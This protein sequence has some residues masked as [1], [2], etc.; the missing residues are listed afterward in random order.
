MALSFFAYISSLSLFMQDGS[1]SMNGD[2]WDLVAVQTAISDGVDVQ[3]L[4]QRVADLLDTQPGAVILA[5][6]RLWITLESGPS[7]LLAHSISYSNFAFPMARAE[8]PS[9]AGSSL[10][11]HVEM[12]PLKMRMTYQAYELVRRSL[13]VVSP[14][15]PN[16]EP[17]ASAVFGEGKTRAWENQSSLLSGVEAKHEDST[18]L[19]LPTVMEE[20]AEELPPR[21]ALSTFGEQHIT[22][23]LRG[24]RVF[25]VNDVAGLDLPIASAKLDQVNM[26]VSALGQKRSIVASLALRADFYNS[27]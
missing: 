7:F 5:P 24:L 6:C 25:L 20:N 10:R 8:I 27:E 26:L 13:S 1:L 12:S 3:A 14:S 23:V 17:S 11:G 22:V 18:R 4:S 9:S 19:L 16:A 21:V 15:A 2:V